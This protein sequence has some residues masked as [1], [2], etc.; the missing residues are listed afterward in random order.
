MWPVWR[1]VR[2]SACPSPLENETD[3]ADSSRGGRE[4]WR[5]VMSK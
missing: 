5:V 1:A 4:W 2:K 3:G